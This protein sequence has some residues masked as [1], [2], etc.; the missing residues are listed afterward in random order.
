MTD[1][2]VVLVTCSSVK[3]ARGI[4]R[5]L[6]DERLAAC[7]NILRAPMESIYRWRGKVESAREILLL[8]KTSR[9]R[10]TALESAVKR[11]H[12]YEV[13]EII[14]LPIERGWNGYLA[15]VSDSVNTGRKQRGG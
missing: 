6:V 9:R 3:E 8:I 10:F 7:V 15:W 12:S 4:S 11:L 14:A 13:P 2:I 5:K 1:K